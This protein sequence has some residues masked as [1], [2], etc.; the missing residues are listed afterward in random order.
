METKGG[1]HR[2]PEGG[3]TGICPPENLDQEF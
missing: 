3:K 1:N 2:R